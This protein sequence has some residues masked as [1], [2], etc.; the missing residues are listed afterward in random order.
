[1]TWRKV[2]VKV[3]WESPI[4]DSYLSSSLLVGWRYFKFILLLKNIIWIFSPTNF[5]LYHCL[6]FFLPGS[7]ITAWAYHG[8]CTRYSD[9]SQPCLWLILNFAT[10]LFSQKE[11]IFSKRHPIWRWIVH[12]LKMFPSF[13][14][15]II[16]AQI[17][18]RY[19]LSCFFF[20]P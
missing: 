17:M 11:I 6:F 1:M 4:G 10:R 20:L 5:Q 8:L 18:F 16:I 2:H 14:S 12:E 15:F 13:F 3:T 19:K 9:Q 7:C